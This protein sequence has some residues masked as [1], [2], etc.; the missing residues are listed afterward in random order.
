MVAHADGGIYR[1]HLT[2]LH[3]LGSTRT[4]WEIDSMTTV[5]QKSM[6]NRRNSRFAIFCF[7]TIMIAGCATTG[8][9]SSPEVGELEIKLIDLDPSTPIAEEKELEQL[10]EEI[11][12]AVLKIVESY[13]D[14]S[15]PTE[16]LRPPKV[17]ALLAEIDQNVR[18]IKSEQ[19]IMDIQDSVINKG[20]SLFF[21]YGGSD[22][23]KVL[24]ESPNDIV[25]IE[26]VRRMYIQKI[27]GKVKYR[28]ETKFPDGKTLSTDRLHYLS[29]PIIA[30]NAY[31]GWGTQRYE[32]I[33]KCK[34]TQDPYKSYNRRYAVHE[35]VHAIQFDIGLNPDFDEPKAFTVAV[36]PGVEATTVFNELQY[37]EAL[38]NTAGRIYQAETGD[39]RWCWQSFKG[40]MYSKPNEHYGGFENLSKPLWDSMPQVVSGHLPN[41]KEMG[42]EYELSEDD[43]KIIGPVLVKHLNS[44]YVQLWNQHDKFTGERE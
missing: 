2:L 30:C 11:G 43:L 12:D 21:G 1:S 38:A 15:G 20:Y 26:K 7:L 44:I 6:R 34:N 4:I 14:L 25:D 42:K 13:V 9:L 18:H 17:I 3:H 37:M 39:L 10:S 32:I 28:L 5:T 16:R 29:Q 33:F 41:S 19:D 36:R 31:G 22:D 40:S 8:S 24:E 35:G 27:I 23:R